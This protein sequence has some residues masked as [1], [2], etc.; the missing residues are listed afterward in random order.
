MGVLLYRLPC[1]LTDIREAALELIA[2]TRCCGCERPGVLICSG[3]LSELEPIDPAHSCLHCGAPYGDVLCTECARDALANQ[4]TGER[5]AGSIDRCLAAACYEG[6]LPRIIRAYKD[7][8][9]ERLAPYLADLLRDA[10]EHAEQSAPERYGGL[11]S[12]ADAVVFVPVTAKALLRRGFDHMEAVTRSFAS[13]TGVA[14]LDALAKRGKTDQRELNRSERRL[15]QQ[16]V[17][18]VVE[19]VAGKRLLLLDDVITT[20]ATARAA[21]DA[22]RFAGACSIDVLALA[23][24][25]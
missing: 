1:A 23:R 21:A 14:F 25:Y 20:G 19:E 4:S 12:S 10:A 15:A 6:P 8:G 24:V 5:V 22:L 11:V 16:G 18:E 7:A 13:G 2:P 3:C 9:E 17:Y